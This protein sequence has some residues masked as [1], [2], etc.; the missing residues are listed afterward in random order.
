[1]FYLILAVLLGL[2]FLVSLAVAV[3]GSGPSEPDRLGRTR[4]GTRGPGI[5]AAVV[6]AVLFL[7][8]TAACSFTTVGARSVAVETGFGKYVTTL[9]SGPHW[10][11]P[12]AGTEEFSTRIQN[13]DLDGKGENVGVNFQGGGQGQVNATV[14]WFIDTDNAKA[15]WEKYNTF[16]NVQK[17][18]VASS[19]KDSFRVVLG[20]YS[21]NDAR[22]GENLRPITEAVKSDLG[23]SLA[24][25]GVKVDSISVKGVALDAATQRSLE[26]IVVANNDIERARSEQERAKIDATTAQIRE[27]AG[28][29]SGPA[30]VRFCLDVTNSWDTAKNG[31]LPAGWSCMNPA[32]FVVT[33]K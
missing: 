12:W 1:V 4:P 20:K 6:T 28:N 19:A 32:S 21:P 17:S 25:Y 5:V 2:A 18:L 26:K 30:L 27:K 23:L 24:K 14:R 8:L 22:A 16:E 3:L 7:V 11:A 9:Q 15:L 29:L 33:N 31:P 10:I 13:L